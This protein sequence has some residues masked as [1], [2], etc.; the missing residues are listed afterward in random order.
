MGR[1]IARLGRSIVACLLVFWVA[2]G[3]RCAGPLRQ[4][5]ALRAE[6][7]GRGGRGRGGR[8][9]G[10]GGG[11]GGGRVGSPSKVAI[12]LNRQ[13]ARQD[14][15]HGQ[16]LDLF[17]MR[18]RDFSE[19]NYAT[20]LN[21]LAKKQPRAGYVADAP[22]VASLLST[23]RL[24]L[25]AN[26]AA[27][28]ARAMA[29]A[30]WGAATL[31][32]PARGENAAVL[33]ARRRRDGQE[34]AIRDTSTAC[35]RAIANGA[36]HRA[37][38]FKAQELANVAWAFATANLDEPELFAA[39]AA[40]ATPRLSRFSAQEL[41]NT[42]WAF[43]KRLGPAVGSAPKNGEDAAC[44]L[45]RAMFAELC[46][47]ACLRFGGGAYGPDGEPL[48][49][50][51]PQELANVCWAMATAGSAATGSGTAPAEAARIMDAPATQPQNLANI[52]WAFAK[53]GCGSPDAVDALFAAV[54]RSAVRRV[55]EFN[56]QELGNTAWAYATAGRDHPAL[57]D[58]I[59]ASAMPRVDR[60]IAQNLANTVWAYA[61]AGHARPD[62]FDAV[63][64]EVARRADEFKPQELANTAWA[65]A[66]AHKA[67]PGDRPTKHRVLFDALA[68]SADHRLRDFNN[69]GLSNLAWAYAS[70]G[71]S[72]GNEALF[73]A[74]G[75][76]VSL[77]V[78]EFRPQGLANLVWA[79]ATAELYCP[80]VFEAVADEIARPSGGA[81][82]AFEFNPQEVANTVWAFAKAAVPAP[83]L[84]D[85]LAAAILKLGA[86]HGGDLKAAG[87]TPQELA[88][89]A[90]AY[91]CADHVDG[92]LLLL[93]WRAIVK[94]ARESPDPGALDGSRFNL[95]ELRQLQQVVLYAKYGA[96]RGTTMGG[97][98]AEIA[99]AARVRRVIAPL[100]DVDAR[101]LEP[102]SRSPSA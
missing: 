64:R 76:Q 71:A 101:R 28:D 47:E 90:W 38:E 29:N 32:R 18:G 67:L 62:L 20:A 89:L 49:G 22:R 53:S 69:Q 23:T 14:G 96:R 31:R 12:M 35:L 75:L 39:L 81:R 45:A 86:K 44:R 59:A 24:R 27:W 84:Y 73:E 58:A 7:R 19:V 57:F 95:E 78:A 97:L 98:V 42:A 91:A 33:E 55:D 102:R 79:Y 15:T 11:R 8:G 9:R 51:K 56:A 5:L 6:G 60:F 87:F 48:D 17:E 52:C 2:D 68:D 30:A 50:F 40:S 54:G 61:T 43:A 100:G 3:F 26:G 16:I 85:A 65:Y 92:D 37:D 93:L 25:E 88:N 10:R 34:L 74:L 63:A 13:I 80:E 41:A 21:W 72:D 82:R 46:D 1:T 36:R 99:R 70:A 66:T 94:E 4:N 83:G 77:R